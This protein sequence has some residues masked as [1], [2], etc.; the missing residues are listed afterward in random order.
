MLRL[1]DLRLWRTVVAIT[2]SITILLALVLPMSSL[3]AAAQPIGLPTHFGFGVSAAPGDTWMPQT[4]IAWDYRM[5]YLAGGVNTGTGWETWNSKGT[6]ALYYAQESAQHGYIPVF[7]YYELLQSNGSC[8]GCGEG[9]KDITNLNTASLM[10]AYY[11]NFTLLMKRL[12]PGNYDGIQGFGKT[13]LI[14]IEPDFS[15][16]YAMQAANNNG[17]CYGYC[18]GQGNDPTLLKAAVT[19]SGVGDVAGYPDTYAGHSRALAHLRD[20]YAPNVLLGPEVSPWATGTDIGLDARASTDAAALGQ[21]VGIF[22]SKAGPH[23]VLFNNPLDRDAGQYKAFWGQ[24]RWW[25][26]LNVT[27]PNFH[28]WEQYLQASS[29]ADGSKS[30]LLWQVPEGNQYFDTENNSN[31]H[32]QDNRS[33]YIFGHVA[34]L[35]QAG[36]VGAIFASGNGGNTTH[37]DSM[38]DGVTNPASGCTTDGS[39]SGQICNNHASNVA[40]DDGGFIR[41]SGQAYYQNPLPLTTPPPPT[42]TAVATS[43]AV[44]SNFTTVATVAP[45]AGVLGQTLSITS[46][47]TSSQA[48]TVLV[49]LEVYDSAS[50][51]V[52][53]QAWDNQ[54]FGVGQTANYTAAWQ[55]PATAQPGAYTIAI[56]VFSPGWAT[57]YNWHAGAG[58]FAVN[59][60]PINPATSTPTPVPTS[61]TTPTRTPTAILTNTPTAVPTKT[62]VATA[63]PTGVPAQPAYTSGAT[64][65]PSTVA[66]GGSA[67]IT[68]NV[69]SATASTVVIDTEVYDARG[70]RVFQKAWDS[71]VFTAGQTR[72]FN[73]L[74]AVPTTL[75]AGTY[76]VKVGVFAPGWTTLYNWNNQAA[77][78]TVN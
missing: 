39:S 22:L 49:D 15:G 2:S 54:A 60:A 66:R 76:T 43:T 18:T 40:D 58:S 78:F 36:V 37:T 23:D 8:G 56:G 42:A 5:Q 55:I 50:T 17:V 63:T 31:G 3:Q 67:S 71:Q 61:T 77:V 16:G 73:T 68:T 9:Q 11:A 21:Q 13:A 41:Q 74:W 12:G 10:Q 14:N 69:K 62:S 52:F 75:A 48:A 46:V 7:P 35:S 30:I 53:Q 47:I 51:K 45:T 64:V 59:A 24:N 72:G 33:E 4:G 27:F 19:S 1:A 34:E 32:Y 20:L 44:A 70:T 57:L 28:R 65:S 6:F 29:V 38:N 25:D 26:R